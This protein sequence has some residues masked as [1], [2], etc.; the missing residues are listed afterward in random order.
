MTERLNRPSIASLYTRLNNFVPVVHP[1]TQPLSASE[2]P[3]VSVGSLDQ[4]RDLMRTGRWI[5]KAPA[6]IGLMLAAGMV[7]TA[8]AESNPARPDQAVI[9]STEVPVAVEKQV[10]RGGSMMG[11][12]I[13]W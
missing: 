11:Y 13:L 2:L 9:N 7:T 3:S 8:V 12:Q 1:V 4:R 5:N 10:E 6:M